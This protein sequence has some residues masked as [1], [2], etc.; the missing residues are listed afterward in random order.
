MR[1][2]TFLLLLTAQFAVAQT[3]TDVTGSLPQ[4]TFGFSA[5]GDFDGD[6]DLDLFYTGYLNTNTPGGGGLYEND[7][8]TFT[9]VA[10]SG[11][12]LYDNGE[13]D[14]GDYNNDGNMDLVIMGYDESGAVAHA[15]IYTNN[16]NGTFTAAGVGIVGMYLG[17]VQFVDVD[18]DNNLDVAITGM[19]TTGWT[20]LTRI[21]HNNGNGTFSLTTSTAFPS[22]NIG[23]MKFADFDG[24]GDMDFVLN[25]WL[26]AT[27]VPYTKLWQNNNDGTFTELS[28]GFA[29]IWL[30]DMEWADYDNDGDLDLIISG[31]PA[32]DS[33]MHLYNNNND[34]TFTE[35][36]HISNLDVVHQSEIEWADFDQDGNLD[37]FIMGRHYDSNSEY[38]SSKLYLGNGATFTEYTGF[39]FSSAGIYGNVDVADYDNNNYPDI[40]LTGGDANGFGMA[41]L[42]KNGNSGAIHT[43]LQNQYEIY[44][45]PAHDFVN[46]SSNNNSSFMVSIIDFTGKTVYKSTA[47]GFI[48]LDITNL[49]KGVYLIK[50]NE[51]DKSFIHKLIIK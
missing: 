51:D 26:N 20:N 43:D 30:G 39:T 21:Y 7:N 50:V 11:L 14:W 15:D 16:G 37:L 32:A 2:I 6:G 45:N 40:F 1:K 46:I 9:L 27:N 10:N 5:W 23:K 34:G 36:T 48:N 44:P 8:G 49:A 17:S 22:V 18:G 13:A 28:A 38:Y 31:T 4:L 24:D 29:Q 47:G 42:Y 35:N 3:F 25:G 33:E 19:E 12:P 41:K